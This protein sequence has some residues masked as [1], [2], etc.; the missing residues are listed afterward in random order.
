MV[1]EYDFTAG[2]DADAKAA[3]EVLEKKRKEAEDAFIKEAASE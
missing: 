1:I 2:S 3:L